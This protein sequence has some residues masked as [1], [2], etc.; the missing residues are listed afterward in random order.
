MPGPFNKKLWEFG[1]QIENEVMPKLNSLFNAD[2]KRD[3]DIFDILDFHDNDKKIICEIKGRKIKS[4]KWADTIIPMN[5]VW[6]GFKNVDTGYKVYFV[7]VFT[8]KTKYIELTEDLKYEVKMT[9]TH[10]IEH[11]LIKVSDLLDLVED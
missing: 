2:F 4:D 9:G 7:F 3:A 1:Q 8:D 6:E 11:A 5:K 10:T